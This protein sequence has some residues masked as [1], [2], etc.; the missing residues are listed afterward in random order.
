MAWNCGELIA[1]GKDFVASGLSNKLETVS[2]QDL[3]NFFRS[4]VYHLL[5]INVLYRRL[6]FV[7]TK[8]K[9]TKEIL[10]CFSGMNGK[11]NANKVLPKPFLK[12]IARK[13]VGGEEL[14]CF[15]DR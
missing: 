5:S 8:N 12:T 2:F 1:I 13:T 4:N 10:L 15:G 11:T 9:K 6:K 7:N 3:L 14:L